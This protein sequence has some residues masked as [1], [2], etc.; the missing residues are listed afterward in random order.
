MELRWQ[1]STWA[2]GVL[3]FVPT[4]PRR[5]ASGAVLGT[6]HGAGLFRFDPFC[7]YADGAVTNPNLV[8]LGEIGRG[9]STLVKV[10]ALRALGRER[11]L[12]LVDPK[13]E[14]FALASE[15]SA[16]VLRPGAKRGVD[17]LAGCSSA[18]ERA[19]A[20]GALL[21]VLVGRTLDVLERAAVAAVAQGTPCGLGELRGAL[22]SLDPEIFPSDLAVEGVRAARRLGLQLD[23]IID[24]DLAGIWDV[25]GRARSCRHGSS[26]T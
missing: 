23:R 9:K 25:K 6:T 18:R 11:S 15:L 3:P 19:R 24:G 10:L 26:S 16:G 13:G 22:G 2:L 1:D 8:V 21:E 5:A 7:A 12:L 17:P 20:L 14:Y 4:P